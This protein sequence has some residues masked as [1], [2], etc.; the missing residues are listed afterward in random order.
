MKQGS[1]EEEY[2]ATL[3]GASEGQ[4]KTLPAWLLECERPVHP[5][6]NSRAHRCAKIFVT[7]PVVFEEPIE[8]P[9]VSCQARSNRYRKAGVHTER[10]R[11][12]E[13]EEHREFKN[14]V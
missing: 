14:N 3:C 11:C 6:R 2:T 13:V 12:V 10:L 7:V 5:A 8:I 4:P 1:V 9:R